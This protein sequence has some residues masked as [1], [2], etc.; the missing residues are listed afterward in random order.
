MLLALTRFPSA[1]LSN[2]FTYNNLIVDAIGN[3]EDNYKMEFTGF[4]FAVCGLIVLVAATGMCT[5]CR[6]GR[7]GQADFSGTA[8]TTPKNKNAEENTTVVIT[9]E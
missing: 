8:A 5:K 2:H 9:T 7:S 1:A 6:R 4:L 3:K